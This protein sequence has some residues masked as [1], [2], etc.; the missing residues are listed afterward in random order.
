M[1]LIDEHKKEKNDP[2][3][4]RSDRLT[5]LNSFAIRNTRLR[6]GVLEKLYELICLKATNSKL[7]T[8]ELAEKN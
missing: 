3:Q 8:W 2:D 1:R 6:D 5:R 4:I 7:K